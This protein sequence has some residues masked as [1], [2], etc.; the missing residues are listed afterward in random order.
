MDSYRVGVK[1]GY[2]DRAWSHVTDSFRGAQRENM[3]RT[4]RNV[5]LMTDK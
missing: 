5:T 1:S 3:L 4:R 2:E